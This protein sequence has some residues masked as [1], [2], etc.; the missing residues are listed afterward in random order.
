MKRL[1]VSVI[2]VLLGIALFQYW[3]PVMVDR[4]YQGWLYTHDGAV[5]EAAE[6][7]LQGYLHRS[8]V[9]HHRYAG[10]II[11]NDI[12]ISTVR[13]ITG[14]MTMRWLAIRE[15][16]GGQ[17]SSNY[18][19]I[20]TPDNLIQLRGGFLLASDLG[21]V[22]GWIVQVEGVF[23]EHNMNFAAPASNREESMAVERR[24]QGGR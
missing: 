8:L 13:S 18:L 11:I 10:K 14:N 6:I 9:S 23:T 21:A 19:G 2:G 16:W 12:P 15:R 4:T 5:N 7:R 24:L 3:N 20:V 22:V 17:G 1:I